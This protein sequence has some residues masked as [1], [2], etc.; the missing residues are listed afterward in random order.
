MNR[1]YFV[2]ILITVVVLFP[3]V[4]TASSLPSIIYM[5]LSFS[6]NDS[7]PFKSSSITFISSL[8]EYFFAFGLPAL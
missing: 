8:P 6:G 3:E 7:A 1:S 5:T 4:S 2:S